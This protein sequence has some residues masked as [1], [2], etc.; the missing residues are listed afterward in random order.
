MNPATIKRK[1]LQ[2]Q[3]YQRGFPIDTL[4][5]IAPNEKAI[6]SLN[7]EGLA[8]LQTCTRSSICP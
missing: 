3:E 6:C 1:P 2:K 4:G 8:C 5:V 7:P